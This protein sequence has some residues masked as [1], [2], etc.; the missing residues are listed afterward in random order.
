MV[1][2]GKGERKAS[3]TPPEDQFVAAAVVHVEDVESTATS[4]ELVYRLMRCQQDQVW[5]G[6]HD[7]ESVKKAEVVVMLLTPGLYED[8]QA[9][10]LLVAAYESQR[11]I[12][13]VMS[14]RFQF[15]TPASYAQ[16]ANLLGRSTGKRLDLRP[17]F[18]KVLRYIAV[19][20]DLCGN[21][22]Q[23]AHEAQ[24]LL[25]RTTALKTTLARQAS[26]GSLTQPPAAP[27]Q[28]LPQ[29]FDVGQQGQAGKP[30]DLQPIHL[31]F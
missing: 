24:L 19:S 17:L 13:P 29:D 2:L 27:L 1:H 26:Q 20:F 10:E 9:L 23:I 12:M 4:D 6:V 21:E 15:P 14:P 11:F 22:L 16:M 8:A 5:R 7:V 18:Q 25:K 3:K 28:E 30:V 31:D